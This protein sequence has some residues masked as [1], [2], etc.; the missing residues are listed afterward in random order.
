VGLSL[1]SSLA[2]VGDIAA[3]VEVP[4]EIV[5]GTNSPVLRGS[6]G[7]VLSFE[8]E[9]Q[10]LSYL[11]AAREV[12][13]RTLGQGITQAEKILLAQD[14]IA[15]HVVFHDVDSNELRTKRL[16]NGNVVLHLRDSY[17][18]QIAAYEL[19]RML[20]M[21]NVPPTV[22]RRFKSSR[23]SAQLWIEDAMTELKRVEKGLKPPDRN[24]WNQQYADMRV[25]DNLINNIDRNQGNLLADPS[26]TL[27][28]IDHTRSFGRERT[29]PRPELVSRCSRRLWQGIVELDTDEVQARLSPYLK[30]PE[31]K[32][33]FLRREKL[34][35]LLEE[36]IM[37][38]GEK[39]V[40]FNIGAPD[41]GIEIRQSSAKP[42]SDQ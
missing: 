31:I 15:A 11:R 12:S 18:G 9:Q 37:E 27:W 10:L 7:Q 28:L 14:G 36:K 19:S 42:D 33:I 30:K 35:E 8:N 29:L 22:E 21:D 13:S 32:A 5:E 34:I 2:I 39:Q 3:G 16:P 40:I 20:G 4:V 41:P 23:G 24:L 6:D 38:Q 25:F 1:Y 17:T 26:W